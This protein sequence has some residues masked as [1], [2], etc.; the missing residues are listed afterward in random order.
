[1]EQ[2]QASPEDQ[3][4][5]NTAQAGLKAHEER[6]AQINREAAQ[7]L[8]KALPGMSGIGGAPTSA[9]AFKNAAAQLT[10]KLSQTVRTVSAERNT[11]QKQ[12]DD[13]TDH[14]RKKK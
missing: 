10:Q 9:K 7:K 11:R 13:T 12:Y 14:G 5:W 4:A 1:V 6:H 2:S 3:A 8:D